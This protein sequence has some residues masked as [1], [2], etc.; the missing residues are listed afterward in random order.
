MDSIYVAWSLYTGPA[1]VEPLWKNSRWIAGEWNGQ[2]DDTT[3]AE[4]RKDIDARIECIKK[5]F[6]FTR[7][8]LSDDQKA[9]GV[10]YF[11]IPEF[12]FHCKQG[13]YPNIKIDGQYDPYDYICATLPERLKNQKDI[14]LLENESWIICAGSILTCNEPDIDR[15]LNSNEVKERLDAL[16]R[17]MKGLATVNGDKSENGLNNTGVHIKALS[18]MDAGNSAA[19]TLSDS[20]Q[21]IDD[22]MTLYRA[23]PLCV[24]R[25]RG[26][27]FKLNE[28]SCVGY[29]KQNEST[30]DLTMGKIVQIGSTGQLIPGGMVT[31]WMAGYPS[32]SIIN[33]DKHCA[34]TPLAAR[35]SGLDLSPD[36]KPLEMGI[37]ICLDHRL[38]RLRRTVG[39]LQQNGAALDNPPLDIQ[40]VPSGG[41]QILVDSVSAGVNGVIF[42]SDGCDPILD[43]YTSDGKQV[44]E[45]SGVFKGITCGVYTSSAQTMVELDNKRYFSHSQLS[46]RFG[47][48]EMTGYNNA[49]GTKNIN[50]LTYDPA[51]QKNPLLDAYDDPKRIPI[52]NEDQSLFAAGFGELHLYVKSK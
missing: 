24:V 27:V 11:V 45:G 47:S 33:G 21:A 30:V 5:A 49:L 16:N 41:M 25:N 43:Q 36:S 51:T 46:F 42:N 13:P 48:D 38:K 10:H 52:S 31:E 39:M 20:Q 4:I 50:G 9:S 40:L 29:E 35:I 37:E 2:N 6:I 19:N 34:A 26:L 32:I 15:L 22:L 18:Y 14:P 23:N 44:I 1:N 3:E 12:Y 17:A 8:Q 28:S 7:S